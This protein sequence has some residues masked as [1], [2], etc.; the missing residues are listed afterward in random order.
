[1]LVF[2]PKGECR[3]LKLGRRSAKGEN[4]SVFAGG[5]QALTFLCHNH[6]PL[7]LK[8]TVLTLRLYP[9]ISVINNLKIIT[10]DRKLKDLRSPRNIGSYSRI[11][12]NVLGMIN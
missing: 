9:F 7:K 12:S 3:E 2:D 5:F 1:M 4:L 8:V 6:Y 11:A 10:G